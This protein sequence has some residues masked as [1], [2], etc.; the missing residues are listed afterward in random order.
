[1]I[2]GRHVIVV[3]SGVLDRV[4]LEGFGAIVIPTRDATLL[5]R[6]LHHALFVPWPAHDGARPVVADAE[7]EPEGASFTDCPEPLL[8]RRCHAEVSVTAG[9]PPHVAKARCPCGVWRWL[10]R[11]ELARAGI[12]I[13]GLLPP[14]SAQLNFEGK[15]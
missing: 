9:T 14:A 3:A 4:V 15:R 13:A 11:A 12:D 8:C 2:Q 5:I 10:G 7:R 6:H 1:M